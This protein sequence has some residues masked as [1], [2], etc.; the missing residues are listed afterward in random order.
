[1][2][3]SCGGSPIQRKKSSPV[4]NLPLVNSKEPIPFIVVKCCLEIER[5]GYT[6]KGIYRVNG[7]ISRVRK[8][9]R[10][11]ENEPY[12]IDFSETNPNDIGHVLKEYFRSVS[13]IRV[14]SFLLISI[15]I[16]ENLADLA[17]S[18]S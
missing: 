5:R 6:I 17:G 14:N 3:I 16:M 11:L 12:L 8:F 10:S 1:M 7:V 13:L 4:F 15:I 18:M 9:I 2:I